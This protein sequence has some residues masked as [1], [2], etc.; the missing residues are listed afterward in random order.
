M[1]MFD[2]LIEQLKF[3]IGELASKGGPGTPYTY[4]ETRVT[5][6]PVVTQYRKDPESARTIGRYYYP[7]S[8]DPLHQ[9]KVS[10]GTW[11]SSASPPAVRSETYDALIKMLSDPRYANTG[12]IHVNINPELALRR[13][14]EKFIRR[15]HH[16]ESELNRK[17]KKPEDATLE[18]LDGLWNDG[19]DLEV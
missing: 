13:T 12:V 15:F 10:E 1:G 14:T 5:R 17:G 9:V 11:D 18:E 16:I 4:A 19:K 7:G 8:G 3:E 6:T 2:G